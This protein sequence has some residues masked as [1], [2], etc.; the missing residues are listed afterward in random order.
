MKRRRTAFILTPGFWLLDSTFRLKCWP[1][2]VCVLRE[3]ALFCYCT[4][5]HT[6]TLELIAANH[7]C[8]LRLCGPRGL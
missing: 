2:E 3:A 6:L 8:R 4:L 7:F 5:T 1:R